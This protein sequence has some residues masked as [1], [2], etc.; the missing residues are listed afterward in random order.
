MAS[1][2]TTLNILQTLH[3]DL[4]A[5]QEGVTPKAEALGSEDV[6]VVFQKEIAKVWDRPAKRSSERDSVK[7][8]TNVKIWPGARFAGIF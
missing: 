1:E 8:G 7:S 4:L 6:V 5:L 3:G 2:T